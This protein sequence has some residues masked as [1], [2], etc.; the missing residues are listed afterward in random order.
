MFLVTS[1]ENN[2]T[3]TLMKHSQKTVTSNFPILLP[4][5]HSPQIFQFCY[6]H[7]QE[8]GSHYTVNGFP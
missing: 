2:N 6:L 3:N 5:N 8:Y 1:R 7:T 4:K